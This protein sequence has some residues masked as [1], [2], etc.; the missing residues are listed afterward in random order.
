MN[1]SLSL[2]SSRSYASL[3]AVNYWQRD[4]QPSIYALVASTMVEYGG[5][6]SIVGNE[7]DSD[8]PLCKSN[9]SRSSIRSSCISE[10]NNSFRYGFL[11]SRSVVTHSYG[12][13]KIAAR[14]WILHSCNGPRRAP[15]CGPLPS[16]LHTSSSTYV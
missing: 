9:P 1:L 2:L 7:L 3:I 10:S 15:R 16:R 13:K 12:W 6:F 14:A 5:T 11:Q 4:Y 8:S